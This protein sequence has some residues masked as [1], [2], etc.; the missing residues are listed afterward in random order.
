MTS[1][2]LPVPTDVALDTDL[3]QTHESRAR[4][5]AMVAVTAGAIGLFADLLLREGPPGAGFSLLVLLFVVAVE[6][7]QRARGT[8][9]TPVQRCI[10]LAL[11]FFGE[12]L[13]WRAAGSLAVI[14]LFAIFVALAALSPALLGGPA[15]DAM[16]VTLVQVMQSG[17]A[18]SRNALTASFGFLEGGAVPAM[19]Q[20]GRGRRVRAVLVGVALALPVMAAFTALLMLADPVF[21]KLVRRVVDVDLNVLAGHVLFAVAFAWLSGG[22]LRGA[23]VDDR[24]DRAQARA[25]PLTLGVTELAIVLGAVNA[26]F[27]SFVLVQLRYLFGGISH[28]MATSHL[29]LADYARRGFHE[30]VFV[31]LLVL[32][33]LLATHELLE[34]DSPRV[35]RLYRV[36]AGTLIGLLFLIMLSAAARL[37]LYM[38]EFGLTEDRVVALAI[39]VWLASVFVLFAATVL[40]GRP[41]G[42]GAS[43]VV[44]GWGIAGALNLANPVSVI[45]RVNMDRAAAGKTFD[46][47][48][49]GSLGEDVVPVVL[50]GFASLP[51]EDRCTLAVTLLRLDSP[52]A[53]TD[54]RTWNR[55]RERAR[56]LL[57]TNRPRLE[58][59]RC[60]TDGS[61][62]DAVHFDRVRS[63]WMPPA[64]RR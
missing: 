21:E 46:A 39:L 37:R 25:I 49:M 56:R 40:R 30:L 31:A 11:L 12:C 32:P 28:V 60:V 22:Y 4:L 13:S 17:L 36:L 59:T 61:V 53:S 9:A 48:Y 38:R 52:T 14:D 50:H 24:R 26:L 54:W 2:A 55:S 5:T 18:I 43:A 29:T 62:T 20:R 57:A 10:L 64:G 7:L 27:L 1:P 44:A 34:R 35:R 42:F 33:L 51:P 19:W 58:S 23:L 6:A 41:R 16:G 3:D 47:A 8:A 45:A 15:W 63:T